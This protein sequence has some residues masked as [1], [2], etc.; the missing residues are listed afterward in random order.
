MN[1]FRL[2]GDLSHL[3]AIFVLLAKIWTT[4][5]CKG[6]LPTLISTGDIVSSSLTFVL[7]SA[8]ISGKS[9]ILYAI[10]FTTRY[11]DLFFS[12][13]SYYNTIMK[14][15]F[16]AATYTTVLLIF[17]KFRATYDSEDD[18]FRAEVL[19]IPTA[20]LAVLV[21]HEFSVLEVGTVAA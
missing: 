13:V 7:F 1:V 17:W 2:V 5:Q 18:S 3:L 9:Q 19:V 14:V 4:R 12:F 15:V 10:V 20:G 8:G 21:N 11:L 6:N 16:I